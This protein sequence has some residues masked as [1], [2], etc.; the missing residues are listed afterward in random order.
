LK[1]KKEIQQ[2]MKKYNSTHICFINSIAAMD[3]KEIKT[4]DYFYLILSL[5]APPLPLYVGYTMFN[6]IKYSA[7][8]IPIYNL[9]NG[10]LIYAHEK[11]FRDLNSIDYTRSE[12]YKFFY[13]I[14]KYELY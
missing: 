7:L 6:P 10:D 12:F 11:R 3:Q 13:F 9:G 2:I 5:F 1:N 4:N 14:S 8:Y